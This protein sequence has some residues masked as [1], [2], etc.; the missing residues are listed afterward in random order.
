MFDGQWCHGP[1]P[2]LTHF[3]YWNRMWEVRVSN[4]PFMG[5]GLFSLQSARK[6]EELIPFVGP[7]YTFAEYKTLKTKLPRMKSYVM[8]VEPNLDIDGDVIKGNV[9]SFI[10]SSLGHEDIG[11]VVWEFRMLAKP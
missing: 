3:S 4:F 10:S 9:A 5:W 7:Q 8:Q 6:G 1:I 11:N 2:K